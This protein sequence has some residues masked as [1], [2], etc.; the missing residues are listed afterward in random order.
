LSLTEEPRELPRDVPRGLPAVI[1]LRREARENDV[2]DKW[3]SQWA[4]AVER[5]CAR[6]HFVHHDGAG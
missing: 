2:F 4:D 3:R 1:P 5:S 6:Q